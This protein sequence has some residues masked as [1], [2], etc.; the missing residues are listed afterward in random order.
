MKNALI[1]CCTSWLFPCIF[2][3]TSLFPTPYSLLPIP[4][5]IADFDPIIDSPMYRLPEVPIAPVIVAFPEGLKELWLRALE[6]PEAEM[7]YKAADAIAQAHRSGMKGLE[8]TK[9]PLLAVL[10][11]PDQ[12]PI[13]RLAIARTLIVLEAR[14]SAPR[15]FR[16]VQEGNSDLR[17][18]IEP[19]LARW[20]YRPIR[21]IWLQRLGE[22]AAPKR[23]LVLAIRGLATVREVS[24]A[25]RL[26][27]LVL[28]ERT[29]GPIRL[30]A[31]RALAALRGE[32][33]EKDAE[34]L[35][36]DASPRGMVS[37]LAA[38]SLLR[39]HSGKDAVSLM[40]RLTRDSEPAVAAISAARL[41]E[42]DPKLIV[43]A[44]EHLLASPDANLRSLA[45][46]ALV[47]RPSAKHIRLL[48]DRLDDEHL[49][50]RAKARQYLHQLAGKKDWIDAVLAEGTRM[51]QTRQWRALEQATILLTQLDHKPS[52]DRFLDL[53]TFDR[54]E[55][56]VT[57][58]WGLRKLDVPETLPRVLKFVDSQVQLLSSKMDAQP[59]VLNEHGLSQ[60]NQLL[61]QR[62][63][64]PADAALRR[65]VPRGRAGTEARTA[66]IWALG[67]I[68]EGKTIDDL[69]VA[70]EARLNDTH[71]VPP[72]WKQ[73]R[74]MSA[75]ALARMKAKKSLPSLRSY[76]AGGELARELVDNA[77][78]WAI[79][80]IT[81]EP[82]PS[83]KPIH[84]MQRNW[85]L[86]P[87]P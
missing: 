36:A 62:K 49:D 34:R 83:V 87:Q 60:L 11:R 80:Q 52:A 44:V 41:L 57:A 24:A 55:V 82:L 65:F 79:A 67:L 21:E 43:P 40:Q 53:L 63:Y 27:E 69:V 70:L 9:A 23:D 32:G 1:G 51:L 77:C 42:I 54:L 14:E 33:L 13:D 30:E 3:A 28:A 71:S 6:R 35:A 31:A 10:D 12:Q 45:V 78:A 46:D 39:R 66:A 84:R 37:R 58:A 74:S 85:F 15:L 86:A 64:R 56:N 20:D 68:H 76:F 16:L 25:D 81:G 5:A 17:E 2:V 38:A 7:R 59:R 18:M 61:G 47:R 50:V 8:T 48:G 26:R 22:P 19:A 73:V 72:E 29:P 4:C 75:I